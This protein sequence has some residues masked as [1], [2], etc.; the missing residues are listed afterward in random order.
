MLLLTW[1]GGNV[2]YRD[3]LD[4]TVVENSSAYCNLNALVTVSNGMLE[5][6]LCSYNNIRV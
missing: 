1:Y 5:A 6:K 4:H 3:D 2:Q